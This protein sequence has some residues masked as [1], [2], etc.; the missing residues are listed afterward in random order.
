MKMGEFGFEI[1]FVTPQSLTSLCDPGMK[2][3]EC[4]WRPH[5]TDEVQVC[6]CS[7]VG[8]TFGAQCSPK[9]Q[10]G[11]KVS[12]LWERNGILPMS[13]LCVEVILFQKQL[14][15]CLFHISAV[16]EKKGLNELEIVLGNLSLVGTTNQGK[17]VGSE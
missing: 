1:D 8:P 3:Q 4:D 11:I 7:P 12:P 14:L 5:I 9:T 15:V 13:T 6:C 16:R 10:Y 17:Y 2:G